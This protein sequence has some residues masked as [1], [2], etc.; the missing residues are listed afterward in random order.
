M[1]SLMVI[2]AFSSDSPFFYV[3]TWANSTDCSGGSS[4]MEVYGFIENACT[5]YQS[6]TC[7]QTS[8]YENFFNEAPCVGLNY[9]D[10]LPFG[11]CSDAGSGYYQNNTCLQFD[12]ITEVYKGYTAIYSYTDENCNGTIPAAFNISPLPL[13]DAPYRVKC[14]NGMLYMAECHND[15]CTKC[16]AWKGPLPPQCLGGTQFNCVE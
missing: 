4:T 13:C 7:N 1:C 11:Q 16:D 10:V 2:G 8:A 12:E 14:E 9:T 6:Y 5:G 15:W 3:N